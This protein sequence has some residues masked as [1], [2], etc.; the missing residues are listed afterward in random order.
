LFIKNKEKD[1][2]NYK[3]NIKNITYTRGDLMKENFLKIV[4]EDN[5]F[6]DVETKIFTKNINCHS[7]DYLTVKEVCKILG[8]SKSRISQLIKQG[9]LNPS[10]QPIS[11][12]TKQLNSTGLN[13]EKYLF[14]AIEI[15][16]YLNNKIKLNSTPQ[17]LN[18]TAQQ[19]NSTDKILKTNNTDP[20]LIIEL[21]TLKSENKQLLIEV[22]KIQGY[23]QAKDEQLK[24][25]QNLLTERADSLFEK[26]AK[27]KEL[28]S[29]LKEET[30]L[31]LKL[32]K[33]F[34]KKEK[35]FIEFAFKNMSWWKKLFNS[36]EN[37]EKEIRK[38]MEK[39]NI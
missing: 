27:I 23:A 6:S 4:E 34:E 17:P 2:L 24:Q 20:L 19:L 14:S 1:Y 36:K 11:S 12:I 5:Y 7:T 30:E 25:T 15:D 29:K 18:S 38:S 35:H 13:C 9:K 32:K 22:G 37:I 39:E 16:N 21:E 26:E 8:V 33:E 31:Q 10:I 28:D 3:A